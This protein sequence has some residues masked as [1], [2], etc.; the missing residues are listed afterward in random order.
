M[1]RWLYRHH[2]PKIPGFLQRLNYFFTGCDL[3]PTVPVGRGTRFTHYGAGVIVN[4]WAI[5]GERVTIMPH[6]V[7]GENVREGMSGQAHIMIGNDVL[8]G[9]GA[10]IIASKDL[11]IGD[12]SVLGANAVVLDSV[13]QDCLAVGVPA[14]IIPRRK[15]A[16]KD[17]SG[18]KPNS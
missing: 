17:S 12:R 9:V 18:S 3:P 8:L 16:S 13:P 10:K 6:V 5:I 4:N 14:R 15:D 1:A 7:I 2:V 11:Q